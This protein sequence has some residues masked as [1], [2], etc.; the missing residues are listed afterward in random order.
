MSAVFDSGRVESRIMKGVRI[1]DHT[2]SIQAITGVKGETIVVQIFSRAMP[3]D[4]V[5][6]MCEP[7]VST[8]S[9]LERAETP[10]DK[11]LFKMTSGLRCALKTDPEFAGITKDTKLPRWK[12]E[13]GFGNNKSVLVCD[14]EF[15]PGIR[16]WLKSNKAY[17]WNDI[18]SNVSYKWKNQAGGNQADEQ[19]IRNDCYHL[20]RSHS[21]QE[22]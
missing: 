17:C 19:A 21:E 3:A 6:K 8:G 4:M 1:I 13:M 18:R 10:E 22:Y 20:L 11:R 9:W 7:G 16:L 5:K 15:G 2:R 12:I 14:R